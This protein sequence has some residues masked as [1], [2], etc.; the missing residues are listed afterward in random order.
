MGSMLRLNLCNQIGEI[1]DS[2]NFT[3]HDSELNDYRRA[4]GIGSEE[5]R[6]K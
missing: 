6:E 3:S 1:G 2:L 4:D 5:R